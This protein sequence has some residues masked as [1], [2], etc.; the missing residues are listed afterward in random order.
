[1]EEKMS[2]YFKTSH[3]APDFRAEGDPSKNS[4]ENALRKTLEKLK[5]E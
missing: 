3:N 2:K 4:A 5:G 1:M